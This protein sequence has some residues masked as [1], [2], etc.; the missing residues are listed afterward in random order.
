M[1]YRAVQLIQIFIAHGRAD[2][3]TKVFQEI[4]ADLKTL[5]REH[6]SSPDT[7]MVGGES[8]EVD[9]AVMRNC[10]A[11]IIGEPVFSVDVFPLMRRKMENYYSSRSFLSDPGIPG[12]RSMGRKCL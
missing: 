12:V 8:G 5:L 2:G 4:L 3:R 11:S 7:F 6:L 10:H 9:L 1:I